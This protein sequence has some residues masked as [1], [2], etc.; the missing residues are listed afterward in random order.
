MEFVLRECEIRGDNGPL[1]VNETFAR[2]VLEMATTE[3]LK[4][5]L[6][7]KGEYVAAYMDFQYYLLKNLA[8]ILDKAHAK[9]TDEDEDL[10][11]VANDAKPAPKKTPRIRHQRKKAKRKRQFHLRSTLS[12]DFFVLEKAKKNMNGAVVSFT[13]AL[14]QM[15]P[16]RAD[17]GIFDE[18]HVE[19]YGQLVPLVQWLWWHARA[20]QVIV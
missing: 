15:R 14:S 13:R 9:E 11:L 18:L 7:S 19:A 20:E 17:A 6:A 16:G 3:K 10:K 5:E 8:Q 2:V 1:F 4:G 12:A